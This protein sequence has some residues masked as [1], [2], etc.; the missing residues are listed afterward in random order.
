MNAAHSS[1]CFVC[2]KH[3]GEIAMP[4]GPVYDDASMCVSH[5]GGAEGTYL[6]YLM[7]EPKRH[8]R[9]VADLNEEEA[10]KLGLLVA[11][12]GRALTRSEGAEHV[13][14]FVLGDAAQHLHVHV[15][16]R[17]PG[18]PR[19]YRGVHVDEWPDAPRGGEREIAALVERLGPYLRGEETEGE[20]PYP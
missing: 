5:I 2:R 14:V 8:V 3:G 13:Y 15:V 10:Q 7:I 20:A 18:A 17:Y 9:G 16:A 1:D 12:A 19:Q 11:R 6:G 4:G